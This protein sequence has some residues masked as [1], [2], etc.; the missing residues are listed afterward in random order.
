MLKEKHPSKPHN[1]NIADIFFKAGYIEAWG[2]GIA[3]ILLG[4][5]KAHLPE[6]MIEEAFGGIQI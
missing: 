1:K 5:Q 3:K 2:R 4:C 6:P